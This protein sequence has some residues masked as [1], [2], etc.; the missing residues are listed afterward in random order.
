MIEQPPILPTD[1]DD[2]IRRYTYPQPETKQRVGWLGRIFGS[3]KNA[4]TNIAGFVVC[5]LMATL[6]V[7]IFFR[8]P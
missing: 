1:R 7:L 8:A 5:L 4:P 2:V 6:C 3:P